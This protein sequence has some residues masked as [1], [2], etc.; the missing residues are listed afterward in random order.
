MNVFRSGT[1]VVVARRGSAREAIEN[2]LEAF[3]LAEAE[4]AD[5]LHL[6]V[7]LTADGEVVVA[8]DPEV[9]V[10]NQRVAVASLCIPDLLRAELVKG[11][12]RY[13]LPLLRDVLMRYGSDGRYLVEL[14]PGPSPRPGLL[15]FRVA[16]LLTQL[17]A[18]ERSVVASPAPEPLRRSLEAQPALETAFCYD[19]TVYRP[20]GRLWPNLP[21]G[22]RGIAP[23][24]ALASERLFAEA[25]AEG[26]A[27]HV[28]PVNDPAE[29][30]RLA[31]L[32]ADSIVTDDVPAVLGALREAGLAR[33]NAIAL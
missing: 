14:K 11:D 3:D 10:G 16:A 32:G 9:V 5:A 27:V 33:P 24:L 2:T 6:D 1:P 20:E 15:E 17:G 12:R 7:R 22:C 31:R 4:G 26:I 28:S 21:A 23:A 29:A 13:A 8:A 25:K 30:L 19:G 18:V